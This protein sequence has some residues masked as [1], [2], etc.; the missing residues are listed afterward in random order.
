MQ[1]SFR[2]L[3]A[4]VTITMIAACSP[5]AKIAQTPAPMG[6]P[7]PRVGLKAGLDKKAHVRIHLLGTF[8]QP[9]LG[10]AEHQAVQQGRRRLVRHT[11]VV[12][13]VR[14]WFSALCRR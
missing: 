8:D 2:S 9:M 1:R 5:P 12:G 7:D 10:T 6:K 4:M 13:S 3:A 11:P 14:F